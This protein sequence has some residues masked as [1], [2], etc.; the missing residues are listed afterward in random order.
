MRSGEACPFPPPVI[1]VQCVSALCL[2]CAN[3]ILLFF[4][5]VFITD[6]FQSGSTSS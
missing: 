2:A 1:A 4:S 5:I 6:G 3:L